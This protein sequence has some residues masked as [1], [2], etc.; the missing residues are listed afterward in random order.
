MIGQFITKGWY[1]IGHRISTWCY[2]TGLENM[3]VP[4]KHR[5]HIACAF[6]GFGGSE[7]KKSFRIQRKMKSL[8]HSLLSR[9]VEI[10]QYIAAAHQ[11]EMG[12]WWIFYKIM[13]GEKY[14]L[15]YFRVDPVVLS[16]FCKKS[17]ESFGGY[18]CSVIDRINPFPGLDNSV[19]IDIGSEYL[20]FGYINPVQSLFSA[21]HRNGV[22]FLSGG[23]ARYPDPE[24]FT[25]MMHFD[26][27]RNNFMFQHLKCVLITEEIGNRYQQVF[28][29]GLHLFPIQFNK[30]E[31]GR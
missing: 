26:H 28:Q 20:H 12:E 25:V 6:D 27:G 3:K 9:T 1:R 7:K 2:G 15:S 30:S 22:C 17:A 23:T 8:H 5:I 18:I 4:V 29:Q 16:F 24:G 19:L 31:I 14:H 13:C 10:D 21:N 11:V